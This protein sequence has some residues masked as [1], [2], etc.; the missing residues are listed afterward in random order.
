MLYSFLLKLYFLPLVANTPFTTSRP[1][2]RV[3]AYRIRHRIVVTN[4]DEDN[5]PNF[6][7]SLSPNNFSKMLANMTARVKSNIIRKENILKTTKKDIKL[8]GIFNIPLQG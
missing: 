2:K 6:L 3:I 4:N 7:Y 1:N 5:L 8:F